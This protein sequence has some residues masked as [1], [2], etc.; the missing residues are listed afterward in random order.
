MKFSRNKSTLSQ[1]SIG[2]NVEIDFKNVKKLT[3]HVNIRCVAKRE[4]ID[5][6]IGKKSL[7]EIECLRMG[8]RWH[9]II[10]H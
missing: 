4:L 3:N 9:H 8:K 10:S 2:E 5:V 1:E 7:N 6:I